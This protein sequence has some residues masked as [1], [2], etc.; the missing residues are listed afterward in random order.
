MADVGTTR[1]DALLGKLR[2]QTDS[3]FEADKY[4]VTFTGTYVQGENAEVLAITTAISAKLHNGGKT[5]ALVPGS[6]G[7]AAPGDEAGTA[8]GAKTIAVSGTGITCELTTGDLSTEH[9][10]AALGAMGHGICFHVTYTY[11]PVS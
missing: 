9:A 3:L 2:A 5:I 1:M 11:T 4:T 7:L 8:I 6:V 10:G